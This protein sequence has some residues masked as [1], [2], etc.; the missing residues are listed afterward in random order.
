L[1]FILDE[2]SVFDAPVEK[3]WRF[4][5][6]PGDHHKHTSMGNRKVEMDGN[7]VVLS[8]ETEGQGGVKSL[9]KIKSTPLAPVGRSMEYLEGPLAGSKAISYYI[10]MGQK[11]GITI[12]GEYVSKV[13]P[14]DQIMTVI[15]NQLEHSFNEDNEN[16]KNFK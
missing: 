9:I 2:G 14:E 10:P 7:S 8:F 5:S 16:L 13:I 3:I 11:T 12:V 6:T 4:M 15:M 1:V